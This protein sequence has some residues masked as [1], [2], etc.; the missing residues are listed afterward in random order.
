[1]LFNVVMHYEGEYIIEVEAENEEKA[2]EKAEAHFDQ[3]SS[4]ELVAN[5]EQ[6]DV[7]DCYEKED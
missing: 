5:F 6:V 1:M 7:C 3:V 4:E 2:K